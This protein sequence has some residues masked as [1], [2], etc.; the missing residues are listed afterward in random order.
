V[1]YPEVQILLLTLLARGAGDA[2]LEL[3]DE[4]LREGVR[5]L[6]SSHD[7]DDSACELGECMGVV[8][9]TLPHS[10]LSPSDYQR[11]GVDIQNRH[12][13]QEKL[14]RTLSGSHPESPWSC[15][16]NASQG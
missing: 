8:M 2:V 16:R 14:A 7:D 11:S 5:Q 12:S 1:G 6:E 10:S 13:V 15:V 4:L 9:A 3:G